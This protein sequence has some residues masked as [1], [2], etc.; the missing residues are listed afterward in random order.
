MVLRA[1]LPSDES[2]SLPGHF[3][4][5]VARKPVAAQSD[6]LARDV[7]CILGIP[8]DAIEMPTVVHSIEMAA[9]SSA[10]FVLSTPN[11]NFLVNSL[12]DPEFRESLLLSDLCPT[13][14]MPIVWIARLMGIPI[15]NRIAGSD[16]FE[17][18]KARP[19][20][21]PPLRVFLFGAT[22]SVAATAAR[23]LNAGPPALRCVGWACPGFG[24]IEEMSSDQFID[25]INLSN[26]DFLVAALGANKGQLWLQRNH[27]RLRIP[28]RAHLGATINFQAGTV[29]RAPSILQRF[30][31]EWLWRIQQEPH[32]W[33]RYWYDGRVLLRLTFNRV[34]PL[35]ISGRLLRRRCQQNGHNLVI[36]SVQGRNAT[37][38]R[39]SG[40]AV[41]AHVESAIA[42]FK[43]ALMA[44]TN[45][46]IDFSQTRA[47]DARF[48]GLL[49]MLRKQLRARDAKL[50]ITGLSNSLAKT[51]RLNGVDNLLSP[52]EGS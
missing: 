7:Y 39:L 23:M 32:L 11:L 9:A 22:E 34:L 6:D 8:I 45:V 44:K 50:E 25:K 1:Q 31:L 18:L 26:A 16:I 46:V 4:G 19:S 13:D 48:L 24:T 10:P 51:F 14:G 17:A 15:K 21:E 41:I 12:E 49:L 47:I 38:I 35:A 36:E 20:S 52:K 28:I 42:Y 29:K 43:E 33:R 3:D 37:T 30:G 40:F 5:G 2:K 27:H